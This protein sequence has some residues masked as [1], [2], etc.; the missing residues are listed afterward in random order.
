MTASRSAILPCIAN[1]SRFSSPCTRAD[2]VSPPCIPPPTSSNVSVCALSAAATRA[3][4]FAAFCI[5]GVTAGVFMSCKARLASPDPLYFLLIMDLISAVAAATGFTAG[6]A[7]PATA[8]FFGGLDFSAMYSCS[9][10]PGSSP[11]VGVAPRRSQWPTSVASIA[12]SI[13]EILMLD[14]ADIAIVLLYIFS[15]SGLILCRAM[16]VLFSS[17]RIACS[18][19]FL[20]SSSFALA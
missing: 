15:S 10:F 13:F 18:A 4:T 20:A 1:F 2:I 11:K 7:T 6:P 8:E 3:I 12:A 5:F 17:S 16:S 19:A 14:S 9:D